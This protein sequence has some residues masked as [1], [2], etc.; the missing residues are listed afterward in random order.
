M[1]PNLLFYNDFY[2]DYEHDND[3]WVDVAASV[4]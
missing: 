2:F 4:G 1:A 3:Q